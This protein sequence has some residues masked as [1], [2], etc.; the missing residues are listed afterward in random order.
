[1]IKANEL[2]IGNYVYQNN[3]PIYI[4]SIDND[5]EI[6]N[7]GIETGHEGAA[8]LTGIK[9]QELDP[10][11]LTPE[12]LEK[13]GFVKLDTEMSGCKVWDIPNTHWRVA[14]S[15]RD[16]TMFKLWH[17]QVSPPTW[18]LVE[19]EYL[20]QLQNLYFALTENE[21]TVNL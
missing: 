18:R 6:I 19:F 14:M 17:R 11:P 1:M 10:I 7:I 3:I 2:R 12:I 20:H 5:Y 9:L 8:W 4:N 13:A 21:L 15:Y 16:E